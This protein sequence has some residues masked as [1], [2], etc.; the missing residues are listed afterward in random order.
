MLK[1]HDENQ[2]ENDMQVIKAMIKDFPDPFD[3]VIGFHVLSSQEP[4]RSSY[5]QQQT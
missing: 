5:S 1:G 2:N 3:Y 4:R